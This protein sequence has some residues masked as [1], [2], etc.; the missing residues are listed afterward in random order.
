MNEQ[1]VRSGF[2]RPKETPEEPATMNRRREVR[3]PERIDCADH[4][5]TQ[6]ISDIMYQVT[7][8]TEGRGRSQEPPD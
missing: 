2:R 7:R 1:I 3:Q 8:A 4:E 6:A 5:G